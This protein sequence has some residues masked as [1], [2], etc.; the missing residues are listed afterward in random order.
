M[1]QEQERVEL[2]LPSDLSAPASARRE[3]RS[4]L[5]R[6]RLGALLDPVLLAASELV[7][8]AVRYGRP[9]VRMT[10]RRCAKGIALGVHDAGRTRPPGGATPHT[11]AESGRGLLLV[12]AVATET[13]VRS[14]PDG[15][16]VWARFDRPL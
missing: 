3:V 15:K 8:N 7:T 4:L 5:A 14:E 2:A 12:E 1:V 6:W 11:D 10:L 9:P 13:G 16:V